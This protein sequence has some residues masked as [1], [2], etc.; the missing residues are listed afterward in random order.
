[1]K[2]TTKKAFANFVPKE[3]EKGSTNLCP[4]TK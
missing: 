4:K 3:A 1:M 2:D